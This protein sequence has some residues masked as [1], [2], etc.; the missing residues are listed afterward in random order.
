MGGDGDSRRQKRVRAT[1]GSTSLVLERVP[2]TD[3][4]RVPELMKRRRRRKSAES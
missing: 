4:L 1:S 3:D 2:R